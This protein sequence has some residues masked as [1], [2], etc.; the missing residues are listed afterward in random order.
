MT[1]HGSK[2]SKVLWG[3]MQEVHDPLHFI[4]FEV[5]LVLFDVVET[6]SGDLTKI[7]TCIGSLFENL[8]MYEAQ[9]VH[10]E[11]LALDEMMRLLYSSTHH[12]YIKPESG[13]RHLLAKLV[14]LY[15]ENFHYWPFES[16]LVDYCGK[17]S[18]RPMSPR[19]PRRFW[20]TPWGDISKHGKWQQSKH[21]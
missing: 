3:V 9:E 8:T 19:P 13:Q 14:A 2:I 18:L 10:K 12:L 4:P 17:L 21:V 11:V 5:I 20:A 16:I 6:S 15:F 7:M 1:H